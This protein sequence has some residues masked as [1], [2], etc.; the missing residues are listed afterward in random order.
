MILELLDEAVVG[1]AGLS[2][3]CTLMGLSVRTVQRWR[4]QGKQG[5]DARCGPKSSPGNKLSASE[6]R[7][8][9]AVANEPAHRDLSPKQLVPRLADQGR[10]LACE[11]T[12]YRI[13]HEENALHHRQSSRPPTATRP[14]EYRAEGPCEVFSW[15]I[16]YLRGPIRGAFY[17]LYLIEDI[18]SRKIVGWAVHD[19]ESMDHAARLIDATTAQL[20]CDP[21]GLVLHSDNGSPMKGSTMLATLQRLGIVASFSRP[22]VSDD[23]PYSEALF[24]MLKY[25]PAYPH[26]PFQ[27]L[28]AAQSWVADFVSWYNTRHLHSAIGFVT[29]EDRHN[30][31]DIAILEARRCVYE[32]ARE[33]TPQ[34]WSRN[35][36]QWSRD[37]VVTLNPAKVPAA[38]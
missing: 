1:G 16:T 30:G 37:K 4:V 20:G 2:R 9:L 7:Q 15:D 35:T 21:N 10:Y 38:A 18:W 11:S 32:A 14:R 12:F 27:S 17:Y 29:P 33:R 28:D 31:K 3:A 26:E 36:R 25:R 19:T 5:T 34:R 8:V 13:L 24:R 22:Q 6:R 23:N